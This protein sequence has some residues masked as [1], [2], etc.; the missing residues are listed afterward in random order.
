MLILINFNTFF[1]QYCLTNTF[2]IYQM[3]YVFEILFTYVVQFYV[4]F[5]NNKYYYYLYEFSHL[6]L[7]S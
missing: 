1:Q 5:C 6:I 7:K 3:K 2:I 4:Y